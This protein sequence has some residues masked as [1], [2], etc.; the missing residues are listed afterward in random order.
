MYLEALYELV[1][2]D[3]QMTQIEAHNFELAIW[4][5]SLKLRNSSYLLG[6]VTKRNKKKKLNEPTPNK[7]ADYKYQLVNYK[8]E[9]ELDGL[10]TR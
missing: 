6:K 5:L 1:E 7:L 3:L 2:L 10:W 9:H 8:P 4:I